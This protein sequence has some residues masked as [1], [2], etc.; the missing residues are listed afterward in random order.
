MSLAAIA[1]TCVAPI[2]SIVVPAYD[3]AATIGETLRSLLAQTFAD[4][5]VIVV[6]DG[7][8]DRTAEIV[9]GFEDPR[10]RLVRQRNRGLAGA[11][12]TGIAASRGEFVGFCDA[13][14]LWMPEKLELHVDH[15][16]REPE[17]GISFAGSSMIDIEGRPL[18][19]AQRPKLT[20][21]TAADVFLRNPIGNGSAAV[22]RRVAFD[23]IAWRPPQESERDWWFDET[24]RQSDDIE[25]WLRFAV[26]TDWRIEGI[27][28]LLTA[29]RIHTGA[30]S[31]DIDR[32]FKTWVR[33]RD[34][35]AALAPDLVERHG[36]AATAYQMRYLARRA[37]SLHQGREAARL[38]R[39][40]LA[41][42]RV[43]LWREPVKTVVTALAAEVLNLLGGAGGRLVE[44]RLRSV[45]AH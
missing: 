23:A 5:E 32:Q 28:G 15:L 12:N 11:H 26:T 43:P 20:G 24:F 7:S 21:L 13:D 33:M 22:V 10:I 38:S 1:P 14:D 45:A 37:V 4:F 2:A 30:L 41:A 16:R 34:K 39:A 27:P 19:V 3:A 31:A 6:D 44:A 18:R 25:G 36:A 9:E 35:I 17:V 8:S 40:S 29:Y 42:S